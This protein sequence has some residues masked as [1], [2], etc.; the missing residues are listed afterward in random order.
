[1]FVLLSQTVGLS[2]AVNFFFAA[3]LLTPVP[4]SNDVKVA[5][6]GVHLAIPHPMV[7]LVPA[8]LAFV[9]I[10]VLPAFLDFAAWPAVSYIGYLALPLLLA[11]LAQVCFLKRN[12]GPRI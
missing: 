9:W 1:M 7:L 2:S 12:D 3:L 6:D 10:T 8:V 5:R 4:L 11:A